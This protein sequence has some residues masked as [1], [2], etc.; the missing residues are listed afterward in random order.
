MSSWLFTFAIDTE[1]IPVKSFVITAVAGIIVAAGLVVLVIAVP[2]VDVVQN[3]AQHWLRPR[4][5]FTKKLYRLFQIAWP[6]KKYG[7]ALCNCRNIKLLVKLTPGDIFKFCCCGCGWQR[8]CCFKRCC[9]ARVVCMPWLTTFTS[10]AVQIPIL[11]GPNKEKRVFATM[12]IRDLD[13]LN[14]V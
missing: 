4:V 8:S 14:L 7:L 10:C 2:V 12:C 6:L 13:K 1:P 5:I 9:C 3:A 11:N